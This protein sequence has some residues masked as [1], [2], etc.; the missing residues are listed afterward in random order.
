MRGDKLYRDIE[1]HVSSAKVEVNGR[2]SDLRT[3]ERR[4]EGIRKDLASQAD[5]FVDLHLADAAHVELPQAIRHMLSERDASLDT[6]RERIR[7]ADEELLSTEIAIEEAR[8]AHDSR[9][10][11]LRTQTA[12]AE[13]K[14]RQDPEAQAAIA[15]ARKAK[16]DIEDLRRRKET[17]EFEVDPKIELFE[18]DPLFAYLTARGYGTPSYRAWWPFR[19]LDAWLAR[20]IRYDANARTVE[21]LSRLPEWIDARIRDAR[22]SKVDVF[23]AEST[24]KARIY[25]HASRAEIAEAEARLELDRRTEARSRLVR[26]RQQD[27][28]EVEAATRGKDTALDKIRKAYAKHLRDMGP[29]YL[30]R[31]VASN[32]T[33]RDGDVSRRILAQAKDLEACDEAIEKIRLV[34][35][36]AA[37]RLAELKKV[38]DRIRSKRMHT[39]NSRY[40][41]DVDG[42]LTGLV[43]GHI[44][45]G[46]FMSRADRM[47]EEERSSSS[48]GSQTSGSQ[49][50]GYSNGQSIGSSD[51][52]NRQ[53]TG[54]SNGISIGGGGDT[55]P[56]PASTSDGGGSYSSGDSF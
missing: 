45:S 53:S 27:A 14:L 10:E 16:T 41:G 30:A 38:E 34:R 12:L 47:Y 26:Q 56:S 7:S 54:Y 22:S 29:T 48:Y 4:A 25:E 32:P 3:L 11:E 15:E 2:D 28:K 5:A 39:S 9:L 46:D 31:L 24:A 20:K 35:E 42:L 55:S 8:K 17:V 40:D 36:E 51:D 49:S 6:A 50:G 23:A 44:T 13:E 18:R 19:N 1:K 43:L 37:G 52:S 21:V 33:G